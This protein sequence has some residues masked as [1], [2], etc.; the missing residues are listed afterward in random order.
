[1]EIIIDATATVNFN[2]KYTLSFL[3]K[4]YNY[5]KRMALLAADKG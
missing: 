5:R 2:F 1:M 4:F 3:V